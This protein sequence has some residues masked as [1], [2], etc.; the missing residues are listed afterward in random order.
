[1]S[2]QSR[3]VLYA[4]ITA[5]F[6]GL[7]AIALKVAVQKLDSLTIVWLRFFIAF[8]GVLIWQL[9]TR[10]AALKVLIKPPLILVIAAI[11]LSLNY[12]GFMMG[13][14]YTTPNNAQLFIQVGPIL[15]AI[16]G[17]LLFRE[18]FSPLQMTGFFIAL[19]GF[20]FFYSD[21][22]GAFMDEKERYNLGVLLTI[23][24]AVAWTIYAVLQKILVR[25]HPAPMLNLFLFGLPSLIYLPFIDLSPV[26]QVHWSWWLLFLFLGA[27]TLISYSTLAEAFKYLE[28]SKVS[29]II[30]VNPIITFLIMGVLTYLR[31]DWITNER[32]SML[33][34]LGAALVIFGALLVIRKKRKILSE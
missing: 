26:F 34:L 14:Y 4:A 31:V 2:N 32:F 5:F 10:P 27:N 21:Q 18:R 3:G 30:F 13:I 28:A 25:S 24:G 20:L 6:W 33:T 16:S 29:V 15:L 9:Y 12:L 22:L 8:V 7:L 1:M 19:I 17:F 23:G 11:A